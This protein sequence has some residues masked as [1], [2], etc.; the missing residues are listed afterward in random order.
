MVGC[1]YYDD[2][3]YRSF[4]ILPTYAT[5]IPIYPTYNTITPYEA[6]YGFVPQ[7]FRQPPNPYWV[8]RYGHIR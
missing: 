6:H 4:D 3:R 5:P 1:S 2:G 8:S 7:C